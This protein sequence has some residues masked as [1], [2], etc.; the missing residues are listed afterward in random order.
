MAVGYV[1]DV[2]R[3]RHMMA[4]NRREACQQR[5]APDLY[6]DPRNAANYSHPQTQPGSN[7]ASRM[8]LVRGQLAPTVLQALV[9]GLAEGLEEGLEV[10]GTQTREDDQE[11]PNRGEDLE[12]EEQTTRA[13]RCWGAGRRMEQYWD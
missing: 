4:C 9:E 11:E 13:L 3:T 12:G 7:K 6:E 1:Q 10:A 5:K 8:G 2:E